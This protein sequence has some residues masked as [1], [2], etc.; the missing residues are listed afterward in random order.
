MVLRCAG[1]YHQPSTFWSD[2]LQPFVADQ[3]T[4]WQ[5]KGNFH[6]FQMRHKRLMYPNRLQRKIKWRPLP[7]FPLVY[8]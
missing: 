2:I 8:G 3:A 6:S 7:F 4:I 1:V 5:K